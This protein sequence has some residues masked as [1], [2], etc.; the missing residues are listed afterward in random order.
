MNWVG[1]SEILVISTNKD[2]PF[3]SLVRI[4]HSNKVIDHLNPDLGV[5]M[6]AEMRVC[7]RVD[8]KSYRSVIVQLGAR[9]GRD[10]H[11]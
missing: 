4:L 5:A 1:P 9:G 2:S 7:T 6:K 10:R 11:G 3:S 8:R